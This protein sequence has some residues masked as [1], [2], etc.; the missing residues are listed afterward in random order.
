MI[1]E[2]LEVVFNEWFNHRRTGVIEIAFSDGKI[3]NIHKEKEVVHPPKEDN[4][5][6]K[7]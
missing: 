4:T 6:K 7:P 3:R 2:W 5:Y 1:P